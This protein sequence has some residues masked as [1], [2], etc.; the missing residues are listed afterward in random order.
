MRQSVESIKRLGFEL[1]S[2]EQSPAVLDYKN[3][4]DEIESMRVPSKPVF[5]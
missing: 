5:I 3:L 4:K 1:T 2:I